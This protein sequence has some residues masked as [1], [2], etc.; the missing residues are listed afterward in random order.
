MSKA[1]G[2]QKKAKGGRPTKQATEELN[3]R[4]LETAAELFALQGFSATSMEQIAAECNA[5]KD[6]IYRRYPSKSHLFAKLIDE[7]RNKLVKELD[8]I[9]QKDG[10]PIE[11]LY[12][13]ARSLLSINLR[14]QLIALH[15]VALGEAIPS[16][17]MQP[18]AAEEDPFM[19]RF[20]LLIEEAQKEGSLRQG[21][22]LFIA[23]QLL[24]VTS[25]KPLISTMN[26][27][28]QYLDPDKQQRYFDEAWRLFMEGSAKC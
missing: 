23:D 24:Y 17:V 1:D 21:D 8:M 25:M 27:N 6:T 16:G 14:P 26:G 11:R 15:R 9:L 2:V 7:F 20:A 10:E 22:P 4:I 3:Q 12:T 28:R 18:K 13:Y 5:G 19:S